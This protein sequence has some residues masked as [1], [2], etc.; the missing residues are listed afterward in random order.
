MYTQANEIKKNR[1][2]TVIKIEM[3][4]RTN[5]LGLSPQ[6]FWSRKF[7]DYRRFFWDFRD[8]RLVF[9]L[10]N[11][12]TFESCHLVKQYLKSTKPTI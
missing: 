11:I 8:S 7:R 3:T 4:L 12:E 2:E 6:E 9:G 1:H 5:K 10:E